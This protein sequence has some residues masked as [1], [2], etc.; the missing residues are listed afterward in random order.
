M[1][2]DA[3]EARAAVVHFTTEAGDV[4]H[5]QAAKALEAAQ[6][7]GDLV[8]VETWQAD[9]EN[10]HLGP[11]GLGRAETGG[12][13]AREHHSMPALLQQPR[14]TRALAVERSLCSP[15]GSLWLV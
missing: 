14:W 7:S 12:P 1:V 15:V 11:V 4:D 6:S 9:I 3:S 2:V 5:S 13:I 8:A 10:H